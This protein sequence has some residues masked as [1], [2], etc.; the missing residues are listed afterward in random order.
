MADDG[1]QKADDECQTANDEGQSSGLLTE[2]SSDPVV[3][4]DSNRVMDDL[5]NDKIGILSHEREHA[6]GQPGQGDGAGQ[7]LPESKIENYESKI[8]ETLPQ[9]APNEANLGSTQSASLQGVESENCEPPQRERTQFAAA[10][11]VVGGAGIERVETIVPAGKGHGNARGREG[12]LLPF[13]AF[14]QHAGRAPRRSAVGLFLTSCGPSFQDR[15][16]CQLARCSP[17]YTGLSS[18][19]CSVVLPSQQFS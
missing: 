15:S 3:G 1:C 12:I 16:A 6:A 4:H 10:G 18:G 13:A 2:D 5:T 7:D 19:N 11:E 9:K 14:A 8:D 17:G